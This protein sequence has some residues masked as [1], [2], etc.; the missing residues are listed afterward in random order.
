[1]GVDAGALARM[2][3]D[4]GICGD[5]TTYCICHTKGGV[6]P[7]GLAPGDTSNRTAYCHFCKCMLQERRK[8]KVA[9]GNS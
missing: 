7:R 5:S 9:V 3:G 6:H 1:M 4:F 2:G 8:T